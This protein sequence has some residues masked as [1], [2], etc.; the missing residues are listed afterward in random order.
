MANITV[1]M[2]DGKL[3]KEIK[4]VVMKLLNDPISGASIHLFILVRSIAI[5]E[6]IIWVFDG[7]WFV[8]PLLVVL[9]T[10]ILLFGNYC[11]DG[12]IF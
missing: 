8:V 3:V 5:D 2:V 10:Y 9:T 6:E 12:F 4:C 11:N 7:W 1:T